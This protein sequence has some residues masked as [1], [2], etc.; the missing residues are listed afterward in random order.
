[1]R[2]LLT[3]ELVP[4]G[5]WFDNLRS[6]LSGPHWDTLRRSAYEA[7]GH[8]CEICGGK[9][10]KWPVEAHERWE[11]DEENRVQKL[12]GIIALCPACH[13]CK[14]IGRT[15]AVGDGEA[16]FRHLMLV[17]SWSRPQADRHVSEAFEV[18][19]R[20]SAEVWTLDLAWLD[21]RGTSC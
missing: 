6:R 18:W 5:Q 10:Q 20:R 19:R 15:I 11:Y 2:E 14:H 9:G 7:A 21:K 1:M 4:K 16:A 8:R 3:I 12:V 17:N 13:S